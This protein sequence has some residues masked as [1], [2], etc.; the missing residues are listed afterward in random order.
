MTKRPTE[1]GQEQEKTEKTEKTGCTKQHGKFRR[2]TQTQD[3]DNVDMEHMSMPWKQT[4]VSAGRQQPR[5]KISNCSYIHTE[6][7]K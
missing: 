4:K 5:S 2:G 1:S 7:T 3:Q 6:N